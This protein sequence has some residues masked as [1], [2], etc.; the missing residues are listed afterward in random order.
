MFV[1]RDMPERSSNAHVCA[2]YA[3]DSRGERFSL[4]CLLQ[5]NK[6]YEPALRKVSPLRAALMSM[7]HY[8]LDARVDMTWLSNRDIASLPSQAEVEKFS[9]RQTRLQLQ[10]G[11]CLG[12]LKLHLYHTGYLPAVI[13]FYRAVIDE[14]LLQDT[15][16]PMLEVVPYYYYSL[17]NHYDHGQPW[18]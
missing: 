6:A 3:D 10:Q 12:P 14:L 8:D 18:N 7:R 4:C 11:M 16:Y 2:I 5:R 9:Y 17:M 1:Y 15:H 13:G